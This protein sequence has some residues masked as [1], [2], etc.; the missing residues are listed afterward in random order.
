MMVPYREANK[1][2]IFDTTLRDGE[3][4]P[5]ISL[6][7][8]EKLT[9]AHALAELGVDVIEAGFPIASIGD[10]EAVQAI[11]RE[12]HGPTICGLARAVN[13]DIDRAW[14]AIKDAEKPRIHTFIATSKVHMEH[15]LKMTPEK[16]A[17][18]ANAA[19]ARAKSYTDDVEF[20]PED[21]ARTSLDVMLAV[22]QAAVDAGATTINIPDTVG[23]TTP[24]EFAERIA[25]VR[26]NIKG[27]YIISTH[28]H[29]DLG[30]ATANSLA[31]VGAG[32]RQVEVAVNGIGERAGNA[33]LEEIVM[34]IK[35]KSDS[36]GG[37]YTEVDS[38]LITRTS[39]LVSNLTGYPVQYNKA[40][41]GRNAFSHESGIH[42]DGVIKKRETY[43]IIDPADVGAGESQIILGKHSGR[44]AISSA[45]KKL[46]HELDKNQMDEVFIDFKALADQKNNVSNADLS[47]IVDS[48]VLHLNDTNNRYEL[49][50][51]SFALNDDEKPS[52]TIKIKTPNGETIEQSAVGNGMVDAVC[53]AIREVVGLKIELV[54]YLVQAV[55]ESIDA[56]ASVNIQLRSHDK[57]ATGRGSDTDVVRASAKAYLDAVNRLLTIDDD[58]NM[59]T[60]AR[61]Q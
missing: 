6:N 33:A 2:L 59:K 14:E 40:I 58:R 44:A 12:V 20:S 47:T 16:V 56:L 52:A 53:T 60:K 50:S 3:Q 18:K 34:A 15:K 54:E 19:V 43:E 46:G 4:S 39:R 36:Y 26:K 57:V 10:F 5:G 38:K 55:T 31:G 41:V 21:A 35:L 27:D 48:T 49:E 9:I 11:A 61:G 22:I 32:A 45:L 17:E 8:T 25:E 29:N 42:Q 37:V 23:Y 28:C 30:M 24:H 1:V 13:G 7:K 51:A